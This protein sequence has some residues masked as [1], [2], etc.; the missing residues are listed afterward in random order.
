LCAPIEPDIRALREPFSGF[1][2]QP[3]SAR[4]IRAH[5]SSSAR[6]VVLRFFT[7][8]LF[9]APVVFLVDD[10]G[11]H[12]AVLRQPDLWFSKAGKRHDRR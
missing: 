9:F 10:A 5:P 1:L 12:C 2:Y 4:F 6:S 7:V 11:G 8:P 3:G